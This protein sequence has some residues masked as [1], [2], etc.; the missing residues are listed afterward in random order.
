[1]LRVVLPAGLTVAFVAVVVAA[2]FE[3]GRATAPSPGG[4]PEP[5]GGEAVGPR[6][7]DHWH[8]VYEYIVCGET[9]PPAPTRSG[10][11]VH[12]HSDGIIHIHPFAPGEEGAGARLVKWFEYG[13]GL[14]DED[15]VRLPGAAVTYENGDECPDGT[16]GTV[17]VFVNGERLTDYGR[18]IPQDGDRIEIVFGPE[19]SSSGGR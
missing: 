6:V 1:M 13:G 12:T 4:S 18:Y 14:L 17:Q 15:E 2:V 19:G 3:D 10:S 7:G 5:G 11:G 8:A 16:I 9:Q